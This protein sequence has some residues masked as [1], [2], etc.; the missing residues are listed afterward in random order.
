MASPYVSDILTGAAQVCGKDSPNYS[1]WLSNTDSSVKSFEEITLYE[2]ANPVEVLGGG[3]A[4]VE[5]IGPWAYRCY[6]VKFDVN[7]RDNDS[8]VE[9]Q[10]YSVCEFDSEASC[11]DCGEKVDNLVVSYSPGYS[12]ILTKVVN[13]GTL[14]LTLAGCTSTQIK[15]IGSI[16]PTPGSGKYPVDWKKG[17]DHADNVNQVREDIYFLVLCCKKLTKFSGLLYPGC[18]HVRC[19]ILGW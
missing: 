3:K 1:G 6:T 18:D 16:D 14:H 11:S 19:A 5:E 12:K 17:V 10:E 15:A 2:I 8:S 4:M 9:Y 13:E 7:F